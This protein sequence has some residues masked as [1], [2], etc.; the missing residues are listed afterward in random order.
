VGG[1]DGPFVDFV[2]RANTALGVLAYAPAMRHHA[3]ILAAAAMLGVAFVS[4]APAEAHFVLVEPGAATVQDGSGN[5]QKTAPCGPNGAGDATGVVT[6]YQ[7][8]STITVTIDET[9]FHPGH[10]R[11]A[12]A[13]NDP[14]ELPAN[15]PITPSMNDECAM[16]VIQDPPVFPVLADG[17][18][19][20]SQA[21]NEP[22]SFEVTLPSDVT[23]DNCTLQII[24]YMSSHGAP[25]FY[26]HCATIAIQDEPVMTTS[27]SSSTSSSGAGGAGAGGDGG[28]GVGAGAPD[29]GSTGVDLDNLNDED[30]C[31]CETA[32]GQTGWGGALLGFAGL[33]L[34]LTRRR[35]A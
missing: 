29:G 27:A 13:V 4:T 11:V 7:S 20:H 33:G 23:C 14:S 30:G 25:C 8:G 1:A 5:P 15:P 28:A 10:Y 2:R 12:L 32:G 21:F 35:R 16:T 19:A 34:M 9:I 24:Q 22:Q 31:T 17:M 18:L 6:T 26:H 3:I